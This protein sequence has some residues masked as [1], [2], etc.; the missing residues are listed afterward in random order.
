LRGDA[1]PSDPIEKLR[2]VHDAVSRAVG[3]NTD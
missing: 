1:Y 3:E 2:I